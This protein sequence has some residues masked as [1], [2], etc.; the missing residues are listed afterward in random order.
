MSSSD[1]ELERRNRPDRIALQD[2]IIT[3][4]F[5]ERINRVSPYSPGAPPPYSLNT[6]EIYPKRKCTRKSNRKSK[7]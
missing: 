3:D 4:R 2:A 7:R 1:D 5:L 6:R